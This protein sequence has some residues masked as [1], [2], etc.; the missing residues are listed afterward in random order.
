MSLGLIASKDGIA[1]DGTD[2]E[3]WNSYFY[4]RRL[5]EEFHDENK[6]QELH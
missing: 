4:T 3:P 1:Q 5:V 2:A 6:P